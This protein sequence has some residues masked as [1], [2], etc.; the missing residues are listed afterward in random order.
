MRVNRPVLFVACPQDA[1]EAFEWVIR[2]LHKPG[3]VSCGAVEQRSA[4][5]GMAGGEVLGATELLQCVSARGYI[6]LCTAKGCGALAVYHAFLSLPFCSSLSLPFSLPTAADEHP[7]LARCPRALLVP[8]P[9]KHLL[10][11]KFQ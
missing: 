2:N 3:E 6:H 7:H 8:S 11:R 9:R 1:L 4:K 5:R 10:P